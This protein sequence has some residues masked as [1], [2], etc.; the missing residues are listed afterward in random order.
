MK[1]PEAMLIGAIY[2]VLVTRTSPTKITDQF[3]KGMGNSYADI[4]GVIITASVFVAGFKATG[5]IGCTASPIA[6]VTI[7]CAGLAGVNPMDMIKRTAPGMVLAILF[8]AL[9]ML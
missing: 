9:F 1:V 7:V 3:F 5:A 4:M 2:A 6:E 8:L